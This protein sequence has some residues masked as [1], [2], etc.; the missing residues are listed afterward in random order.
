MRVIGG[1][2]R[3]AVVQFC[4]VM[5]GPESQ[6]SNHCNDADRCQPKGCLRQTER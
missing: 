6:N 1:E 2:V 4:R 3:V 5:R